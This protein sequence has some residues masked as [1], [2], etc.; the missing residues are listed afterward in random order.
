MIKI[1]KSPCMLLWMLFADFCNFHLLKATHSNK[2]FRPQFSGWEGALTIRRLLF[3]FFLL[4][5]SQCQAATYYFS[6]SGNNTTGK[7]TQAE[8]YYSVCG[9]WKNAGC[10]TGEN[11]ISLGEVKLNPGDQL[12]F[13][14]GD[15][16]VGLDAQWTID[17]KGDPDNPITF[18]AYGDP[19]LSRP[20]F[21]GAKSAFE[22]GRDNWT[23]VPGT[24]IWYVS[25]I[26]WWPNIA[27]QEDTAKDGPHLFAGW[28]VQGVTLA[29]GWNSNLSMV[30][31]TYFYESSTKRLY[32]WRTDNLK[33][34]HAAGRD[35]FIG[36]TPQDGT[37]RLV[38]VYKGYAGTSTDL[39]YV[40]G[41]YVFKDLHAKLSSGYGFASSYPNT[42]FINCLSEL[43]AMEGF[44]IDRSRWGA[45][46]PGAKDNLIKNCISRRNNMGQ[47]SGI[48]QSI[49]IE[50]ENV[51]VEDAEVYEN[52]WA[53]IDFLDYNAKT[54]TNGGKVINCQVHNNGIQPT[55]RDNFDP[56]IYI[57]G[58]SD[59]TIMNTRI[60][61]GGVDPRGEKKR[62]RPNPGI[63]V[64]VEQNGFAIGKRPANIR[65]INNLVFG[66][67]GQAIN[68]SGLTGGQDAISDVQII[69]NTLQRD[70][71]DDELRSYYDQSGVDQGERLFGFSNMTGG[72]AVKNN[73][74]VNLNTAR[75]PIFGSKKLM[76]TGRAGVD[77][78]N[79]IYYCPGCNYNVTGNSNSGGF[80]SFNYIEN[81]TIDQWRNLGDVASKQKDAAL[82]KTIITSNPLLVDATT[83]N[84]NARLQ[85][86]STAF[87]IANLSIFP[88]DIPL[89]GTTRPDGL[90]D[91]PYNDLGYHYPSTGPPAP[92]V[93]DTQA[94]TAPTSL[95]ATLLGGQVLLS[96][97]ASTDNV[98]VVNYEVYDGT[99]EMGSTPTAGYA[100]NNPLPGKAFNF[101]VKALDSAN[102][103]SNPS[104]AVAYTVPETPAD[105]PPTEPQDSTPP[106]APSNLTATV[107][108]TQV[109]LSWNASTDNK[110]VVSYEI[111]HN[112]QKIG[113]SV[114][115]SFLHNGTANATYNYTVLAYDAA[116]NVSAPSGIVTLTIPAQTVA[117]PTAP[118]NLAASISGGQVLLSWSSSTGNTGYNIYRNGS[119]LKSVGTTSSF[120]NGVQAGNTYTYS[121]KAYDLYAVKS[122]A[123]NTVSVTIPGGSQDKDTQ[124]PTTPANFNASFV[125]NQ[126]S[127]AWDAATDNV[128]VKTYEVFNG[129]IKIVATSELFHL[130]S[131]PAAGT[132]YLLKVR[133][134]DA[135][136][137]CSA[138][139]GVVTVNVPEVS[140]VTPPSVPANLKASASGPQFLLSWDASTDDTSVSGYQ[141]LE[142]GAIMGTSSATNFNFGPVVVGQTY[143]FSVKA[144]DAKNNFSDPSNAVS[145]TA[146]DSVPPNAPANLKAVLSGSQATLSWTEATDNIA[147][148]GYQIFESGLQVD[149]TPSTNYT[150][151]NLLSGKS[152]NYL[153]KAV[154]AAGNVSA[155]S[156]PVTVGVAGPSAP[157][158][159]IA[160][161]TGSSIY[162]SW[163]TSSGATGFAVYRND[164]FYKNIDT[165]S[166]YDSSVLAGQT[167]TYKVQAY[168]A[169]NN[170]SG[171]S[172]SMSVSLPG[173]AAPVGLAATRSGDKV[174]MT[175]NPVSGASGYNIYKNGSYLK[176]MGTTATSDTVA[177]G[178]T[179]TYT[180]K[181][182]NGN[183]LKSSP[184]NAVIV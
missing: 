35:I 54:K 160:Y 79:N 13:K 33:P 157:T 60:W 179:F 2:R 27:A 133:A 75:A 65:I 84:M 135:A 12:L 162:V 104:N 175:W 173:L 119:Y 184:S 107:S 66:N 38:K 105:Q 126:I 86:G 165:S 177:T 28:S 167:Y 24:S 51:T 109:T 150:V 99:T 68:I 183:G 124:I 123:S 89:A 43:N 20:I 40:G 97:T 181:A 125:S 93:L 101:T 72:L 106:S 132:A 17:A 98:G 174:S 180:V 95:A 134:C 154:D 16:W 81:M 114:S 10:T 172:N 131:S 90:A 21:R 52:A 4:V 87:D 144:F 121:V 19:N 34:D 149:T 64:G 120:D 7:G 146:S 129:A 23:N 102:N 11:K 22:M 163:T 153:V 67:M 127:A 46:S 74:F 48:G 5:S 15:E 140:D 39:K 100:I 32:V 130:I 73:I 70:R 156:N 9:A 92:P 3:L 56:N 159:L 42:Q 103:A 137:N 6:T 58:G 151:N 143:N 145:V 111:Q 37:D 85:T 80:A 1:K 49:T 91:N 161:S 47:G 30:R 139:S 110:G 26:E 41:N 78:E 55:S 118:A 122:G 158:Y 138:D 171:F 14:R 76:D 62:L 112:G 155:P 29:N 108:G 44:I 82:S 178:Q 36:R 182:Y 53:G 88:A 170:Y 169:S 77:F 45:P 168:N 25:G 61:A 166:F 115:T 83:A 8:P 94:P 96:W 128:G 57:D 136:G 116:S 50:A 147:V 152:Y 18:A 113:T 148:T 59:I 164:V 69:G 117:G 176:S 141:I 71:K 63:A 142:G 31:G